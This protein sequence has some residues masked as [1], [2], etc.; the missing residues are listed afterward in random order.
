M[1]DARESQRVSIVVNVLIRLRFNCR[2]P[3]THCHTAKSGIRQNS[4]LGKLGPQQSE[5]LG[6]RKN[7]TCGKLGTQ[8]NWHFKN[9]TRSKIRHSPKFYT[10]QIPYSAKFAF[11][12]KLDT[13]QTRHLANIAHHK[14]EICWRHWLYSKTRGTRSPWMTSNR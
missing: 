8:K 1:T 11:G 10:R 6:T 14:Y 4:A 12:K 3:S 2:Q 13:W 7:S 9:S 5:K